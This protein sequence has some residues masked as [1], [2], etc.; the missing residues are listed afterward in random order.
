M[1]VPIGLQELSRRFEKCR[2][3]FKRIETCDEP[4]QRTVGVNM[5]LC[6]NSPGRT[7]IRSKRFDIDAIRYHL[8]A[9]GAVPKFFM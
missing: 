7:G 3:I 1:G 8:P 5:E 4:N 2:V 6:A 9:A